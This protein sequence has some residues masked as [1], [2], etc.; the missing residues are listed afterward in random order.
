MY[1]WEAQFVC[2]A[3]WESRV[4]SRPGLGPGKQQGSRGAVCSP[5]IA[6]VNAYF[7]RAVQ[8]ERSFA[9]LLLKYRHY[10]N[11]GVMRENHGI[12]RWSYRSNAAEIASVGAYLIRT[13]KAHIVRFRSFQLS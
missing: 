8:R 1:P 12:K 7:A 3:F 4:V 9:R 6:L 5:T 13:K 10:T 11:N 2:S